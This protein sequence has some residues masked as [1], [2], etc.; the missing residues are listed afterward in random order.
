[1]FKV[2]SCVIYT[3]ISNCVCIDCLGSEREKLSASRIGPGGCYKNFNRTY[4]NVLGIG[5]PDM[6][7]NLLSFRGF[8]KNKGSVVILKCPNR[9]FV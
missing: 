7:N 9:I 4:D 1:M 3:I 2:L 5:I 6:L 8:L